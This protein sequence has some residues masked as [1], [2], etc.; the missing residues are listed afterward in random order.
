MDVTPD[1]R[2]AR[3]GV[4][5]G[6]RCRWVMAGAV[7]LAV[8]VAGPLVYAW[9]FDPLLA[10]KLN[11][12]GVGSAAIVIGLVEMA[13]V[14]WFLHWRSPKFCENGFRYVFLRERNQSEIHVHKVYGE[15]GFSMVEGLRSIL[16]SLVA[17]LPAGHLV[18]VATPWLSDDRPALSRGMK[19][20]LLAT[21]PDLMIL[22]YHGHLRFTEN[23]FV[24]CWY[25]VDR[26]LSLFGRTP[27][28]SVHHYLAFARRYPGI[29]ARTPVNGFVIA[30]CA[31]DTDL[32]K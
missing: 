17:A 9:L 29:L 30:K 3:S 7:A 14:R 2:V 24:R 13:F 16:P 28:Q 27:A 18:L 26:G 25:V 6:V 15:L 8:A 21:L 19:R 22:E 4:L 31:A 5:L 20:R 23:L 10:F 12:Y 32:V 1:K 11:R